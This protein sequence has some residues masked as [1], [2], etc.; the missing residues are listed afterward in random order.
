M[1]TYEEY[2]IRIPNGKT[3]GQISTLCPECSHT[4]KKKTD[5][6]L[7]VNL[8]Q[9]IWHCSHCGWSGRLKNFEFKKQYVKPEWKN[10]TEISDK[11]LKY[12]E[13]RKI[14]QNAIS[15]FKITES[16]EY[17]PQ[18]GIGMNTINFNYFR[19]GELVNIKYRTGNKLFKLHK[20]SELIFYN[21]D[22][23]KDSEECYIVEGEMDCLALYEVGVFN[24]VSV[25]NGAN[26]NSNNLQYLDNCIDYFINKKRIHIATDNDI[27]GRKLRDDLAIRFG[28]YRCDYIDF[29]EYKD[30]N[31]CL[32]NGGK[33]VLID[34]I[35]DFKSFPIEGAFTISDISN[36]IND[37][38]FNGLDKGINLEIDGFDLNIVKGYVTT[39]TGIPSHG[40]SDFL[41]LICLKARLLHNWNGAFYS[42]EN[43]PTE[44][45]FAK[46][47][48]KITGK[49]WDGMN[50]IS[51]EEVEEV[52]N[53]LDKKMFFIKPEKDFTLESILNTVRDLQQRY[54]MDYF[55]IDA[56]NKL[57]HK[58]NDTHAV[59]AA[60]DKITTFCE[61]NNIHAFIVA[62]PAKVQ[63]DK[64]GLFEVPTLYSISGSSNFYNKTDNG[65]TVY[66]NFETSIT[67][68]HRQ[69]VKFDHWGETGYSD[70]LYDVPSKRYYQTGKPLDKSN[71][72][73][74]EL[75]DE[76]I[77]PLFDWNSIH[78]L[79]DD[80]KDPF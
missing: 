68:I 33:S 75:T 48:R 9:K 18:K 60:Y 64:N 7:G 79:D 77:K 2:K 39:I 50:R 25:P 3:S 19:E 78:K 11:L 55:V 27:A 13:S 80:G 52:K 6:C 56:W 22:S 5:K 71:W 34:T 70:Y 51:K 28:K 43:R 76:E 61:V 12:F 69:K 72:I 23:I 65:I 47:V 74:K 54:G 26:L 20:D 42:P 32:I 15:T 35:T 49:N 31:E 10:N 21:L 8:D 36:E 1:N 30:S 4:R 38:Y 67:T 45:H 40:K 57:E 73:K 37:L 17:M 14:T 59:G 46:M 44:L 29:K 41:D 66:R 63:K 62:H 58:D 24:V 53:Y 16:I